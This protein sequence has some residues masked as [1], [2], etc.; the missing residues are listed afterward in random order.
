M[1]KGQKLVGKPIGFDH[2]DGPAKV[3]KSKSSSSRRLKAAQ[4]YGPALDSLTHD[5]LAR[6]NKNR[7]RNLKAAWL[8]KTFIPQGCAAKRYRYSKETLNQ[9]RTN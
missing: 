5:K 7:R 1:T 4:L 2:P 9:V 6:R 8:V 3:F